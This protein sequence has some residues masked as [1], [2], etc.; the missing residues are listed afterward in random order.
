[1]NR[2]DVVA[3]PGLDAH[4]RAMRL[5][6]VANRTAQRVHVL[7]W[8]AMG[9]DIPNTWRTCAHDDCVT[10]RRELEAAITGKEPST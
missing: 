9:F 2:S 3:E 5:E 1:M 10:Y 8:F 6:A 7:H 4:A